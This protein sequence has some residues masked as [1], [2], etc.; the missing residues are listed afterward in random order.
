LSKHA[1]GFKRD[2]VEEVRAA[3]T[4]LSV[5]D[6]FT[7]KRWPSERGVHVG[8]VDRLVELGIF[9]P[10]EAGSLFSGGD[11]RRVCLVRGLEEGGCRSR[12]WGRP[13]ETGI[14]HPLECLVS[15]HGSALL[16]TS[17]LGQKGWAMWLARLVVTG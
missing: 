1:D 11:V 7:G 3:A 8:Y 15:R 14:S 2:A 5:V 6:G 4:M 16:A 17:Y 10:P 13:S 9:L 12:E